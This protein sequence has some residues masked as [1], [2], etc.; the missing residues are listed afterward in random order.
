MEN[1]KQ[2]SGRVKEVFLNGTWIA[3]TNY[4]KALED[5]DFKRATKRVGQHNSIALLTFH[6][7]YYLEGVLQV[8]NGGP[9]DIKDKFSFDMPELSNE[10]EWQKMKSNF[11][12]TTKAFVEAVGALNDD[13]LDA[14]FVKEDYG[15]YRRNIEAMIEH[16]YYHLGQISLLKKLY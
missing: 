16:G 11:N 13:T 3:F 12:N 14:V 1:S 9:L 10:S 6:I 4:S 7:H 2:L 8:L 15:S 5:V